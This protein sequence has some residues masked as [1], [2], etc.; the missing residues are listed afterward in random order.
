MSTGHLRL[1]GFGLAGDGEGGTGLSSLGTAFGSG[2]A[3][4]SPLPG[5]AGSE[6]DGADATGRA[7]GV[8]SL[9][10]HGSGGLSEQRLR[11]AQTLLTDSS[12]GSFRKSGTGRSQEK[13]SMSW[14]FVHRLIGLCL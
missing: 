9:G 11:S 3:A 1:E 8:G 13:S 4:G 5:P 14:G 10:L 7:L 12:Q 2:R 6:G